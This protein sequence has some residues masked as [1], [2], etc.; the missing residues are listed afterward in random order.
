MPRKRHIPERTCVGCG[1]KK[2]KAELLRIARS[3]EGAVSV[4]PSG[5]AAGRGAY[6]CGPGCWDTAQGRGR[7][8][9]SLGKNLSPSDLE[10]L[11]VEA[12]QA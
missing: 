6:V 12:L 9:R 5:K 3:P 11:R 2:P 7:L 1:N 10:T 8:S 4:D